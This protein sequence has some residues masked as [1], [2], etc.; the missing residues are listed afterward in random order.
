MLIV[1]TWLLVG[2]FIVFIRPSGRRVASVS[3]WLSPGRT[4]GFRRGFNANLKL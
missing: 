2:V 4:S 1:A 3:T